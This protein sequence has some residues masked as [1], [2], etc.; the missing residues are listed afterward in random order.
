MTPIPDFKGS[1][2]RPELSE[3]GSIFFTPSNTAKQNYLYLQCAGSISAARNYVPPQPIM[4]S[5]LLLYTYSGSGELEY[6]DRRFTISQGEGF[7][8]CQAA[9]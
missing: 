8:A 3:N 4:D 9:R 5:Y 6:M 1:D 2:L 7:P